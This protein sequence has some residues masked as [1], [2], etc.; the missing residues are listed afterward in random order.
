ME[1]QNGGV[2]Y[3]AG[4]LELIQRG[5]HVCGRRNGGGFW[6]EALEGESR[7]MDDGWSCKKEEGGGKEEE[8]REKKTGN[9]QTQKCFG[10]DG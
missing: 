9:F 5:G 3:G 7:A 10:W 4:G 1:G 2:T 8:E 6:G